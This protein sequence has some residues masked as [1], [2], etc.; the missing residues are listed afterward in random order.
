MPV[1]G[2]H[3]SVMLEPQHI[4]KYHRMGLWPQVSHRTTDIS[5]YHGQ[6]VRPLLSTCEYCSTPCRA[7]PPLL[8][9]AQEPAQLC[10]WAGNTC[11]FLCEP[12]QRHG[13]TLRRATVRARPVPSSQH[14]QQQREVGG[15]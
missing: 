12:C 4:S 3:A 5:P 10:A 9:W 15:E 6:E 1:S 2:L 7:M 13:E 8:L 14:S 11:H